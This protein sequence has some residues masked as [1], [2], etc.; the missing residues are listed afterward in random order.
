MASRAAQS[1]AA[2]KLSVSRATSLAAAT[3]SRP[4]RPRACRLGDRDVVVRRG[5]GAP[6]R[7]RPRPRAAPARTDGSTRAADTA[8]PSSSSS[9]T[10]SDLSTSWL[11]TSATSNSSSVAA[12]D[13]RFRGG[14]V[15]AAG[16]HREPVQR[17]AFGVVE[18][19]VGPVDRVAQR[20]VPLQRRAAAPG[21][22]LE[23]LIEPRDQILGGQRPHARRGQ[24][25][26]ER[27]PVEATTELRDRAR[28]AIGEREVALRVLR[29]IHEQPHRVRSRE[30]LERRV[31]AG[32]AERRDRDDLLARDRQALPAR[33]E[34]HHPRAAL[35][36]SGRRRRAAASRRCSQLSSTNSSR[37]GP[38]YSTTESVEAPPRRR[39]H[40]QARGQRVPHRVGIAHRRELAQP[41]AVGELGHQLGGHLD[42]EAGLADTADARQ[43][44]QRPVAQEARR[45][46]R[47]RRRGRRTS[48]T[49]RGRLPG[50]R[51]QRP[52]RREVGRPDPG[53]RAGT[54][55]SARR[56]RAAG[57]HRDRPARRPAADR[58]ERRSRS[59]PTSPPARRARRPSA[60]PPVQRPVHSSRLAPAAPPRRCGDPSAPATVPSSDPRPPRSSAAARRARPPTRRGA[61]PNTAAT[62]S[63]VVFDE[64]DAAVALDRRHAGSRRG[65]PTRPCIASGCSS[66]R[67]VEPSRSVN[68]NVTVPVGSST[69]PTPRGSAQSSSHRSVTSDAHRRPGQPLV[70]ARGGH[71]LAPRA[72]RSRRPG[73]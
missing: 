73:P 33:R 52:Q 40:A 6:R 59:H 54:P 30:H 47:C 28:V 32:E 31:R 48:S 70:R 23:A 2:R 25:D 64:H 27:D 50:Q 9:T 1:S 12:G 66:H 45:R 21:E 57:A 46:S 55:A 51:I 39:V 72:A 7:H 14:E 61:E 68:R 17:L 58:H 43:R 49:C 36:R 41:R 37:F 24:L 13:D 19:V 42:R 22:Q 34:H 44:H 69:I 20:L 11:S 38:R 67:R 8:L 60:A 15:R 26:R 4:R 62:P 35:A 56:D 18:Q 10:T 29:A 16:E 3:W 53:A 63:P 71:E 65:A 5:G